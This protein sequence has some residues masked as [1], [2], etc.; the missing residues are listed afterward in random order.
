[1]STVTEVLLDHLPVVREAIKVTGSPTTAYERLKSTV[2]A[3]AAI[4][5]ASFRAVAPVI[6]ETV[7]RLNKVKEPVKQEIDNLKEKMAIA[8][9]E[10]MQ[11]RGALAAV[12]EE[13]DA[14][15][16]E[17]ERLTVSQQN[18]EPPKTFEGWTV[19]TDEK[20]YTRLHKKVNGK[21]RGVYIGRHWDENKA[22]ERID[23]AINS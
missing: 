5:L 17:L 6:V 1:M 11:I 4:S 18:V 15:I 16:Q 7:Q 23:V 22:R 8:N 21:V 9:S 2:P 3:I 13:R 19:H 20:G 10:V 12:T 14:L